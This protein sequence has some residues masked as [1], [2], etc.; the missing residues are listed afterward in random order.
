[1]RVVASLTDSSTQSAVGGAAVVFALGRAQCSGTT[2]PDGLAVCQLTPASPGI[3]RL[4]T[5][6]AGTD[7]LLGSSDSIGFNVVVP[8]VPAACSASCDD[9][10]SCTSDA[11]ADGQC[12]HTPPAGLPGVTCYLD[13]LTGALKGAPKSDL[14]PAVKRQLLGKVRALGKLV[15]MAN[16]PGKKGAKAL[17]KL[18]KKL[19]GLVGQLQGLPAKKVATALEQ[20]LVLRARGALAAMP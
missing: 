10:D 9:G 15:R 13:A 19:G 3:N 2:G 6:F 17:K 11:C 5:T 4:T 8:S 14:R 18:Q 1:V 7:Q 20:L 16:H 12:Q